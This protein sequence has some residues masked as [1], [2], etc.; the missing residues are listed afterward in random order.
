MLPKEQLKKYKDFYN[1]AYT[2]EIFTPKITLMIHLAA[3]MALD[4][5][6]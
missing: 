3:A 1:S 2:N 4:C 6:P 5:Y